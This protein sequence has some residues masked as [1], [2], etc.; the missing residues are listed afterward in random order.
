MLLILFMD[1]LKYNHNILSSILWLLNFILSS[2][3]SPSST[4]IYERGSKPNFDEFMIEHTDLNC[5]RG[6]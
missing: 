4:R 6:Q 3:P 2:L 5:L 1:K